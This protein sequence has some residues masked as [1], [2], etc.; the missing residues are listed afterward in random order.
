M[1]WGTGPCESASFECGGTANIKHQAA[2]SYEAHCLQQSSFVIAVALGSSLCVCS[3]VTHAYMAPQ[4][5]AFAGFNG[6]GLALLVP[7]CQSLIAD[8]HPPDAR[9][10]AFGT[11]QLTA[12][13]GGMMGGVFATNMGGAA[14]FGME[15]WRAAFHCVAALS[16]AVGVWRCAA[17]SWHTPS[18]QAP[19]RKSWYLC[20]CRH[21]CAPH[22]HP[23]ALRRF[24]AALR[25]RPPAWPRP[26]VLPAAVHR[27]SPPTCWR[28][29]AAG[30]CA[31][32]RSATA[33]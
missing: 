5:M 9:G 10:R 29:A 17:R 33:W 6:L 27:R 24:G 15:G 16:L 30:R 22:V 21:H 31:W 2:D 28:T 32:Q 14:P 11:L 4:A 20:S 25:G 12:S 18:V 13:L 19:P 3:T 23:S 26:A 7:C 8:L 1:K